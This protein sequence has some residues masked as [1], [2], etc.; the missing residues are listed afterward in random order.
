MKS[1][2]C[3][4]ARLCLMDARLP[5]GDGKRPEELSAA[6]EKMEKKKLL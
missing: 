5:S 4:K 3:I 1:E 2:D 6:R